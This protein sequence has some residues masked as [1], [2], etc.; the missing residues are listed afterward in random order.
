MGAAHELSVSVGELV[1][2]KAHGAVSQFFPPGVYGAREPGASAVGFT[3]V[4]DG[5]DDVVLVFEIEEHPVVAT[6]ERGSRCAEA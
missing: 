2:K 5:G 3:A 1:E 4:A 6:A